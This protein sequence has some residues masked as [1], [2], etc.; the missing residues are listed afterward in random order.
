M[1]SFER[2]WYMDEVYSESE[3]L[4]DD[5]SRYDKKI[6]LMDFNSKREKEKTFQPK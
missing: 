1:F 2:N 4:F 5:L 3:R 6:L